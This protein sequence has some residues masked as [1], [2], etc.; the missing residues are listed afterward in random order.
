M[1]KSSEPDADNTKYKELRYID[2]CDVAKRIMNRYIAGNGALITSDLQVSGCFT[3]G[4]RLVFY[5]EYMESVDPN[6]ST[7]SYSYGTK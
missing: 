2:A 7:Y 6:Y 1:M 5:K 4:Y 3:I